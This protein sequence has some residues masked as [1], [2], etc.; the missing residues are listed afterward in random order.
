MSQFAPKAARTEV[1]RICVIV[2]SVLISVADDRGIASEVE[3]ATTAFVNRED[4]SERTSERW[5]IEEDDVAVVF[6]GRFDVCRRE[7]AS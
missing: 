5:R 6:S 7:D 2:L 4:R 1:L 3:G